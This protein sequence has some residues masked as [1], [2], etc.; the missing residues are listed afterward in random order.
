[1][2]PSIGA[3]R[4]MLRSIKRATNHAEGTTTRTNESLKPGTNLEQVTAAFRHALRN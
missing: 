2:I 3:Q 4:R 1:M